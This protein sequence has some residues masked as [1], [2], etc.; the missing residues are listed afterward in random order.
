LAA[1]KIVTQVGNRS[2]TFGDGCVTISVTV[3]GD[4]QLDTPL[5]STDISVSVLTRPPER[6]A[7]GLQAI[8]NDGVVQ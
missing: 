2:M 8:P 3:Q 5:G 4:L 7:V 1:L 6:T